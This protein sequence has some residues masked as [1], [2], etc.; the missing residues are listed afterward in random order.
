MVPL[1]VLVHCLDTFLPPYD[2]SAKK[3][4][5]NDAKPKFEEVAEAARQSTTDTA[6]RNKFRSHVIEALRLAPAIPGVY[7]NVVSNVTI[8]DRQFLQDDRI[9]ISISDAQADVSAIKDSPRTLFTY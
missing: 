5:K 4:G 8:N 9:Y 6:G 7:R 1:I 2:P 3:D